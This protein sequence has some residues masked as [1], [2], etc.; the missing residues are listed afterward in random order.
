MPFRIRIFLSVFLALLVLLAVGPFLL[1]RTELEG[2][3]PITALTGRESLVEIGGVDLYH[4]QLGGGADT[5]ARDGDVAYLLLH[6]YPSNSAS[7]RHLLPELEL[8]GHAVAYDR[9]G[10]GYSERPL[11]GSWRESETGNPYRPAAQVSQA[12]ELLDHLGIEKAIW[13]GSS[14]GALIALEAALAHPD[15]VEALALIGAPVYANRAPPRW[16]RPLLHT[17][18]MDRVGPL[19]MRQL[20]GPP[21]MNLYSSQWADPSRIDDTDIAAFRRTFQV[22]D[23][24]RGLWEVSKASRTSEATGRLSELRVP[25]LVVTG[26]SDPIVPPEESERLAAEIP[27]ATL[28]LME[29]CG[30]LP[31]EECPAQF[32]ELLLGWLQAEKPTAPE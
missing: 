32:S 3:E 31:Q 23:W 2:T 17:P 7:W 1:P 19:L 4:R 14:S 29:G 5:G 6:G 30:H 22:D 20:G 24:D 28:A 11:P 26:G 9:P 12:L 18:Q 27:G 15:R 10:F 16:L 21:G 8:F 25:T 13:I